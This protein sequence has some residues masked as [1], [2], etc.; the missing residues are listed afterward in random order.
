MLNTIRQMSLL[1][2]KSIK[3]SE[4]P[5]VLLLDEAFMPQRMSFESTNSHVPYLNGRFMQTVN[6]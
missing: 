5:V 3:W 2:P 6:K 1:N 4:T